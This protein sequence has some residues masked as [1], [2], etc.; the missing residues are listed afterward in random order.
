[1]SFVM[2]ACYTKV[3]KDSWWSDIVIQILYHKKY[4]LWK[5][6]HKA[7][8]V[9]DRLKSNIKSFFAISFCLYEAHL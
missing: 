3:T 2:K 7:S 9:A 5:L 4:N 8:S 1:M 6:V